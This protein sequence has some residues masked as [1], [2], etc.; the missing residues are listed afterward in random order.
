M[1]NT[2]K[3]IVP[4]TAD[5]FPHLAQL[6]LEA[7]L[8]AH[9]FIDSAYWTANKQAMESQY[10]PSS[11]VHICVHNDSV[12][13]FIAMVD[14]YL[15]ALF[16]DPSRQGS[17]Y[18]KLLLNYAKSTRDAVTLNVFARNENAVAFYRKRGFSI[19]SEQIDEPTGELEYVMTWQRR[20]RSF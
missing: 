4:A 1:S 20:E 3:C 16:I 18:G 10:L 15:A 13:G 17:G 8:S 19:Q 9:S 6:W 11:E 12:I 14:N 7:S 2:Y 5:H